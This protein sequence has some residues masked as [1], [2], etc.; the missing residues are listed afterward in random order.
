ML[1]SDRTAV[2]SLL[3]GSKSLLIPQFSG[4][5]APDWASSSWD[6]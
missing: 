4:W 6:M 1:V 2:V 3:I 5:S